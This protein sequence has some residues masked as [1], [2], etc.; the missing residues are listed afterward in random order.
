MNSFDIQEFTEVDDGIGGFI[1]FWV[2]KVIVEGYID[3]IS[4]TDLN[5]IQNAVTEQSTHIL[6]IPNCIDGITDKMR[7]IDKDNRYYTIT[8]SDNPVGVNHHNE[9][10]LKYGGVIDG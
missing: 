5:T 10:Y 6:I 4:G 9:I 8:Y 7:V 2:T 1:D 3:M